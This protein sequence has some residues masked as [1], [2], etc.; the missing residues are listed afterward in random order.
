MYLLLDPNWDQWPSRSISQFLHRK[1]T[2]AGGLLNVLTCKNGVHRRR[3]AFFGV[4]VDVWWD[5]RFVHA[6][7]GP[8]HF[9]WLGCLEGH[10]TAVLGSEIRDQVQNAFVCPLYFFLA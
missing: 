9:F 7:Q 1:N 4:S 3:L 6:N 2:V 5:K 8:R 10:P